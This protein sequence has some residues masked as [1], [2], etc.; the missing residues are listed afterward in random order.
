MSD[1]V[2]DGCLRVPRIAHSRPAVGAGLPCPGVSPYSFS[3]ACLRLINA[4]TH[5]LVREKK[6]SQFKSTYQR[7]GDQLEVVPIVDIA[8]DQLPNAFKGVTAVIHAAA[9]LG[10]RVNDIDELVKV[11][12]GSLIRYQTDGWDTYLP[13]SG[14]C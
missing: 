1:C 12:L 13:V 5:S 9:P 10:G 3:Y 11:C 2:V 4:S 7:F 6:A 14:S 8:T